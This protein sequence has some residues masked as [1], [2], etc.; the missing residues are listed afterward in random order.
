MRCVSVSHVKELSASSLM[1]FFVL[2]LASSIV[3]CLLFINKR[4]HVYVT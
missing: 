3:Y 4:N 2:L 1:A